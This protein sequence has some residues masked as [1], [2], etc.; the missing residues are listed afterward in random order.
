M[1]TDEIYRANG[2][3]AARRCEV[4][5]SRPCTCVP[6]NRAT[7]ERHT[8]GFGPT[9]SIQSSAAASLSDLT[10]YVFRVRQASG[11]ASPVKA[12]MHAYAQEEGENQNSRHSRGDHDGRT[13]CPPSVLLSPRGR[14]VPPKL[15]ESGEGFP[16]HV[17]RGGIEMATFPFQTRK[18]RQLR[19][20]LSENGR[21]CCSPRGSRT[22]TPTLRTHHTSAPLLSTL[23]FSEATDQLKHNN[24]VCCFCR[25]GAPGVVALRRI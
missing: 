10:Q 25:D 17:L 8:H 4:W 21:R 16:G 24:L 19:R 23:R 9:S 15:P 1:R 6:V 14:S 3:A 22:R 18:S 13:N 11:N 2:S 12:S 7:R 20:T 5:A